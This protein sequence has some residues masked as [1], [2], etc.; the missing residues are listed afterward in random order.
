MQ[1]DPRS[2]RTI[3]RTAAKAARPTNGGETFG[4]GGRS[5]DD[6]KGSGALS[7]ARTEEIRRR[8][9]AGVYDTRAVVDELAR[10]ML[11]SGDLNR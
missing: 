11:A 4:S 10:R 7:A 8:M 9:S 6:R 3:R 1:I 5:P 2:D